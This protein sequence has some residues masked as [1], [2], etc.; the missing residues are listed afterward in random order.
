[1]IIFSTDTEIDDH[2]FKKLEGY[3]SQ[4]YRLE[5]DEEEGKT[6][7]SEGYFWT[8]DDEDQRSLGEITS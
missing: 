8:E 5:Y 6:V 7:P 4:A 1:V 2:Q 3:I